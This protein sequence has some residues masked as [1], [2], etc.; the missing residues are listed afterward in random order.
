MQKPHMKFEKNFPLKNIN[1]S[2]KEFIVTFPYTSEP[3]MESIKAVGVISPVILKSFDDR[4]KIISG[5]RRIITAINIGIDLVDAYIIEENLSAP[6]EYLLINIYDNLTTRGFNIIEQGHIFYKLANEFH[7]TQN[8]I[9]GKYMP[10]LG[11]NPNSKT[12]NNLISL[13]RLQDD[14]KQYI[15]EEDIPIINAVKLAGLKTKDLSALFILL[16][17]IKIGTNYLH[18]M[19]LYLEEISLRDDISIEVLLEETKPIAG[20]Q[21][22]SMPQKGLKIIDALKDRRYPR[23]AKIEKEI[24]TGIREM[25]LPKEI[26]L[27]YPQYLEEGDW[28]AEIRFK[29]QEQ[30]KTLGETLIKKAED[31][32]IEK[33]ME[34]GWDCGKI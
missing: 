27:T 3:L 24:I 21:N 6:H 9:I 29:D 22:L 12:L 14:I 32:E 7:I 5:Y 26:K 11:I 2:D 13:N 10:L 33:I 28:K 25:R 15:I 16:K 34:I 20:E 23:L 8:E 30:L 1:T 19:L 4:Y 18:Q 31:G 17:M